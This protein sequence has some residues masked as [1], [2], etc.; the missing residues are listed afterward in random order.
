MREPSDPLYG[1]ESDD[2]EE[3]IH[4]EKKARRKTSASRGKKT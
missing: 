1:I 4:V 2:E 3:E